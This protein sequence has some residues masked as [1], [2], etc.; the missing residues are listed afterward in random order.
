MHVEGVLLDAGDALGKPTLL[1]VSAALAQAT[2]RIEL[3]TGV[4]L[5]PMHHPLRLAEDPAAA[6]APAVAGRP[7][8]RPAAAVATVME[9]ARTC[10]T[11]PK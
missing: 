4:I 9:A 11:N 7:P 2:S 3:G 5:A 6:S 10:T 8:D 1:V